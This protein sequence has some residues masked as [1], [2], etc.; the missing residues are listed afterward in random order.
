[1]SPKK[2]TGTQLSPKNNIW[3]ELIIRPFMILITLS[4]TRSN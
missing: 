2:N 1:M 4:F 3:T